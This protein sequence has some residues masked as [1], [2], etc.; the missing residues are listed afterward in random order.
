MFREDYIRD[1][2]RVGPDEKQLERL[3]ERLD[4]EEER[5]MKKRIFPTALLAAALCAALGMTAL[6][7]SPTLRDIL[8]AAWGSFDPYR[9]TVEDV[10]V[11]DQGIRVKLSSV[12]A[13]ENGG[14][15]F[16]EVTDL[17]GDRLD[18]DTD[19]DIY[20]GRPDP[21][22]DWNE[23][24]KTLI[25]SARLSVDG[26]E[27]I[28]WDENRIAT[29]KFRQFCPGEVELEMEDLALPWDRVTEEALRSETVTVTREDGY[30][31]LIQW[32]V[33]DWAEEGY[34]YQKST[35]FIEGEEDHRVLTPGQNPMDLGNGYLSLSSMG[36]DE[37]GEFHIQF[38]LLNGART[39]NEF[40]IRSGRPTRLE[41]LMTCT[42]TVTMMDGGR[43]V[44]FCWHEVGPELLGKFRVEDW[45]AIL[46]TMPHID[47]EWTLEF[48]VPLTPVQQVGVSGGNEFC[49]VAIEKLTFSVMGFRFDYR[50]MDPV[51]TIHPC[52]QPTVYLLDGR[53]V[54]PKKGRAQGNREQE[55]LYFPYEE[56]LDPAQVTAV[57]IGQ[58]YIPIEN[59]AVQ[60]GHWLDAL[61][62]P[63]D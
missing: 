11:T 54:Q 42:E 62:E 17:E 38:E 1:M 13:D 41:G 6:A 48:P 56:A 40:G 4:D 7:A 49:G 30:N 16:F 34:S 2:A 58:W 21:L 37:E 33:S 52:W 3:L 27:G 50:L 15:A 31:A 14:M 10:A 8:S 45:T 28:E 36:F 18:P 46:Y 53:A 5:T 24:E 63:T 25:Y 59:G 32:E 12:L 35:R 44:D 19:A 61:P 29:V 57:A 20:R 55:F 47:G 9:Q 43:Y 22:V 23:E 60:P 39:Y 51:G 26:G